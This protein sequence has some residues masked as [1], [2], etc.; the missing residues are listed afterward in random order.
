MEK[1]TFL[2][3]TCAKLE[4]TFGLEEVL[5]HSELQKWIE[6]SATQE[7]ETEEIYILQ[8]IQKGLVQHGNLW[9]EAELKEYFIG[10]VLTFI[11]FNSKTFHSFCERLI[12][13]VIGEHD[14]SGK[15][16]NLVAKG[17]WE[18]ETPYFCLHEYKKETDPDGDAIGQVLVAMLVAQTLNQNEKTIY[19]VCI[20]GKVW[21]FL[22]LNNKQYSVSKLYNATDEEIFDIFK[23]LK[24][25]KEIILSY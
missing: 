20:K 13:A 7:V 16:D 18:P 17:R 2:N 14:I 8:R 22:I 21:Y 24:A 5:E 1:S 6:K 9:N 12:S 3:W 23:I 11:D 25:L 19:G 15:P 10:P 4:K